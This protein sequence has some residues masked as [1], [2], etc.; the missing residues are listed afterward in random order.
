MPNTYD[1]IST[2]TLVS[3]T[4]TFT[5][6]LPTGYTDVQL[7][8][9]LRSNRSGQTADSILFYVNGDTAGANYNRIEFYDESGTLGSELIFGGSM[10]AQF[11][12]IP[13]VNANAMLFANSI[14]DLPQYTST[15]RKVITLYNSFQI[16]GG[17]TRYIWHTNL[18]WTGTAP[19]TTV[20]IVSG[21]ASSLVAG[22]SISIYGIKK[23]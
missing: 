16:T 3:S 21:S 9:S 11:G 6:N 17:P 8:M 20:S 12:G 5:V 14:V 13:A 18:N 1:L 10:G 4:S 15:N 19:L 23:A 22:S 2:Q 7:R